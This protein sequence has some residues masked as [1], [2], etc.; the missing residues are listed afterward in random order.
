MLKRKW[1]V[2][3]QAMIRR[4]YSL[5]IISMDDYQMMIRTLQRR[6]M[7]KEEPL[8]DELITASPSLL[9]TAVMMLLNENVFTAKEFMDELSFAYNLSLELE[10][11]EYLLNLP[12]NTLG[13][14]KI[15]QFSDLK[16]KLQ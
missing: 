2:S 10:E 4:S 3:I 11:V 6:G 9:K 16:L 12:R 7:R 8:D 15:L 1:K 14:N 5:G 13:S